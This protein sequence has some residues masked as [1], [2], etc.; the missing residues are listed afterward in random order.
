MGTQMSGLD[1]GIIATYMLAVVGLG[2]AAGL[3]R[4]QGE[5]GGVGAAR[6]SRIGAGGHA[7]GG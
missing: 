2:V 6:D 5:R 4:R 1:W 7:P 3:L